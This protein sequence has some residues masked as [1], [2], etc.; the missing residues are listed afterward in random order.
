MLDAREQLVYS[1]GAP[2]ESPLGVSA[3]IN[4]SSTVI[5]QSTLLGLY[6]PTQSIRATLYAFVQGDRKSTR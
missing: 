5:I 2:S 1:S 6:L 3:A 4:G